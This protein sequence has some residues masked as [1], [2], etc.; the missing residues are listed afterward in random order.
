M[1]NSFIL[2][3]SSYDGRYL[4]LTCTQTKDIANNRSAI[5]WTLESLAGTDK[6]YTIGPTI[7]TIAGVKVYECARKG[8]SSKSFPAARGSTSGTIYVSH[9]NLGNAQIDVSLSTAIYTSTVSAKSGSWTLDSIPRKATMVDAPNFNDDAETLTITYSNPAGTNVDSLEACIADSTGYYLYA[10]YRTIDASDTS[11][12]FTLTDEERYALWTA[13]AKSNTLKLRFYVR[14]TIGG[15]K[16]TDSVD[17]TMTIVD[18]DPILSPTVVDNGSV[19]SYLTGDGE[20]VV[21]KGYNSMVINSG[22]VARKCAT[23][24]S[25]K[26]TCGDQTISL[27]DG[28]GYMG[29][30]NDSNFK[31]TVTDSRGNITEQT[32]SKTLINYVKVS[33]NTE[34]N[35]L[36]DDETTASI[37]LT[38]TGNYFKGSFGKI[39]NVLRIFY[40]YKINDDNYGNWTP[41]PNVAYDENSKYS[42]TATIPVANYKDIYTIQCMAQDFIYSDSGSVYSI[43]KVIKCLPV[44]DWGENDF[45]FNVPVRIEGKDAVTYGA[46]RIARAFTQE[47]GITYEANSYIKLF[48]D[49]SPTD[50]YNQDIATFQENGTITINK[51]MTA[52]INVHVLSAP[53]G[54][55]NR[56]WIRLMNYN[57]NWKYTD[58]IAYGAFTSSDISIVLKLSQGTVIGVV[59]VEPMTINSSGLVGSYIEIMEI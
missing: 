4:K 45:N 42:A 18:A 9:D 8:W 33:C 44:F 49:D 11:Y 47:T 25:Q 15:T 27:T 24:V 32:V 28:A 57:T 35:I 30:V 43:E 46:D 55:N 29:Y 38:A 16:Y 21:I 59:T 2:Q 54:N 51:D 22:A 37:N 50:L 1:A 23:I 52:L 26:V 53:T 40:R 7:V 19:S 41:F 5:K 56:S 13:S 17:R 3:S 36:L 48:R 6:Y 10:A 31:F 12:T 14:T 20:N 34:I 58:S 39:D